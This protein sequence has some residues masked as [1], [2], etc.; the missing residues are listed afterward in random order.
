M[1]V[2]LEEHEAEDG[3]VAFQ[4][5]SLSSGHKENW[6]QEKLFQYASLIPMVEMFG[7][8][9]AFVPLCREFPL[10]HGASNVF[11]D[12]LGVSPTGRLVLIE[13]KLWRNPG[14]RR[15]VIAQLFEYASLMFGLTYSDL[16]AKLKQARGMTGENPMFKAVSAAHPDIDEASFVDSVNASLRSGDFLLAIAGDG[17]RSDLHALRNLLANQGGILA[18]LAL[19]EIRLFRDA[20]GRTLLVPNVPVQT[21]LVMREVFVNGRREHPAEQ[22]EH[23]F[24]ER[25][26]DLTAGNEPRIAAPASSEARAKNREFWERFISLARF[27]HPDQTA[28][29]HGGNNYVRLDL[30][31]PVSGLV[32]YR[33]ADGQVG[34]VV[35]FLG[36]E[37]RELMQELLEDQDSVESELAQP[38]RLEF[39]D[40]SKAS[41][42]VVGSMAM[43][44]TP[45]EGADKDEEQMVWL[46]KKTNAFVNLMRPRLVAAT[47]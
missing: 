17:I 42:K 36:P 8:G 9:E 24:P 21:E 30:P 10:R 27:D 14:A 44:F 32:A 18:R 37:G 34:L 4:R 19:L 40:T 7:Q 31:G 12:L 33:V 16:E 1:A 39:G 11:L 41:D 2:F 23:T 28:P 45:K 13:C 6:L 25:G 15:E 38:V 46:L 35:K 29:R 3:L 22:V 5:V 26:E 43:D 47:V 20:S